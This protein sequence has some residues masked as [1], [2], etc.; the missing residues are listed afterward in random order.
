MSNVKKTDDLF[1]DVVNYQG[2]QGKSV[3]RGSGGQTEAIQD[4]SYI[5][6][7]LIQD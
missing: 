4:K 3:V 1:W 2:V 7:R 5:N 6:A